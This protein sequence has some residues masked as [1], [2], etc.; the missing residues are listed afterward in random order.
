LTYWRTDVTR[1]AYPQIGLDEK[2]TRLC[3]F[4]K[5]KFLGTWNLKWLPMVYLNMYINVQMRKFWEEN[6]ITT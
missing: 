2:S 4:W 1:K 5:P 3:V 6:K